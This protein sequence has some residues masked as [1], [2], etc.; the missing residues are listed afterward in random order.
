M[1]VIDPRTVTNTE[2]CV[3][4]SMLPRIWGDTREDR[5]YELVGE[6]ENCES[7]TEQVDVRSKELM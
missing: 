6:F 7:E 1:V 3:V 5:K 2:P 4:T